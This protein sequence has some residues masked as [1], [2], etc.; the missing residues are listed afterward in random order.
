MP[1][2]SKILFLFVSESAAGWAMLTPAK[3]K[4]IEGA[5]IQL[6][7]KGKHL[8]MYIAGIEGA[9]FKTWSTD[10]PNNYDAPNPGTTLVG[11]ELKVPAHTKKS[12]NVILA[13]GNEKMEVKNINLTALNEW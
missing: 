10:P 3:V 4:S 9:V 13:P 5:Q 12:F 7:N 6:V 2:L 11:F 1:G 8:K